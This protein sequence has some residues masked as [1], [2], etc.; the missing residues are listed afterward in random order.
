MQLAMQASTMGTHVRLHAHHAHA[1]GGAPPQ[2]PPWAQRSAVASTSTSRTLGRCAA[3]P[4]ESDGGEGSSDAKP[5]KHAATKPRPAADAAPGPPPE[6]DGGESS[7]DAKPRKRAAAKPRPAADAAPGLPPK[8]SGGESSSD[9]K[10]R[11]RAAAKPRP[12][13]D[14][15]PGLPPKSSGGES[16]SDAKPRKRAAAKPRPAADAAPGLPP[17]SSG[18]ESSSDAKSRK[19]AA[20]APRPAAAAARK[21]PAG[22]APPPTASAP[23]GAASDRIAK[24]LSTL[25]D[26]QYIAVH[27]DSPAVRVKAGPGSGKTRA[28]A[29]RVA[30]LL[31]R[32]VDPGSILVITFTNKAAGELRERLA[33]LLGPDMANRLAAGTFH[34]ICARILRSHV[35]QLHDSGLTGDFTILDTDDSKRAMRKAVDALLEKLYPE[36]P[37]TAKVA[38]DAASRLHGDLS[39]L[40]NRVD[41]L[42]GIRWHHVANG[43]HLPGDERYMAVAQRLGVPLDVGPVPGKRVTEMF[44]AYTRTCRDSNGVDLD[45]LLGLTVALLRH[46]PEVQA[47]LQD[48]WRH[49]LVDEFQDTNAAQYSLV[50]QLRS[51]AHDSTTFVVGDPDQ[52]IYGWRGANPTNME[53]GFSAH[54]PGCTTVQLR[55]N[56]RSGRDILGAAE[57]VLSHEANADVV[58][59]TETGHSVNVKKSE[60]VVFNDQFC[61]VGAAGGRG[62]PSLHEELIPM[63][64][65]PGHVE[66]VEA[67]DQY[68]E[69]AFVAAKVQELHAQHGDNW[70]EIAVLYRSNMQS[71]PLEQALVS[72]RI[73]FKVLGAKPFWSRSEVKVMVSYLRLVA[74]PNDT[75]ALDVALITPSR[76]IGP[77][78]LKRLEDAAKAQGTRLAG[79]LMGDLRSM[80][81]LSD[82]KL[83]ALLAQVEVTGALPPDALSIVPDVASALAA[84]HGIKMSPAAKNGVQ[85]VR[86]LVHVARST[87]VHRGVGA[88][89]KLLQLASGFQQWLEESTEKG[90]TTAKRMRHLDV[91]YN[92]ASD[93]NSWVTRE[94][95]PTP[96]P[97]V[98]AYPVETRA[99]SERSE[100]YEGGARFEYLRGDERMISAVNRERYKLSELRLFLQHVSLVTSMDEM[101]DGDE[102]VSRVSLMTLHL[103]KGLEFQNVFLVGF[104]EGLVPMLRGETQSQA[105][106]NE[107]KRLAY[108]GCTRAKERLYLVWARHRSLY[109]G[110]DSRE[111]TVSRYLTKLPRSIVRT[112]LSDE[113]QHAQDSYGPSRRAGRTDGLGGGGGSSSGW[114][115]PS[116]GR[117]SGGSS[118]PKGKPSGGSSP[119]KGGKPSSGGSSSPKGGKPASGW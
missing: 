96:T 71:W 11:K 108:V 72:A 56:Y 74:N 34:S 117:P 21:W 90:T 104:E 30:L 42:H 10:P 98:H 49:V 19:C 17:K 64:N 55:R 22:D 115:K 54:F 26:E 70:D 14:A 81:P 50:R 12:A 24:Y 112:R 37:L 101:K 53:D 13:A 2:L 77:K 6:P 106:M 75:L 65:I 52:A 8:S 86:A 57:A 61:P 79:L 51:D 91:L 35:E 5:K 46:V 45:D 27:C 48:R 44:D 18:G 1:R 16:S 76:G 93:P 109:G 32:G 20:A 41:T 82:A 85:T 105:D 43:T 100:G 31:Q 73:P 113:D 38:N 40:K 28:V 36:T 111:S 84:Q 102:S 47:R 58:A 114:S 110:R 88:A 29:A 63:V 4:P 66:V 119:P 9:A 59:F 62:M 99:R 15:A 107:E 92:I 23:A 80:A 95:V 83:S 67:G 97:V 25:N 94:E 7:S 60:G 118:R 78:T 3:A 89:V 33:T 103:S 87:V 69:A 116:G 68:G 39:D